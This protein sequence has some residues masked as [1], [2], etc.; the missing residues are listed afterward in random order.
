MKTIFKKKM[1]L[2][3]VNLLLFLFVDYYVYFYRAEVGT[4]FCLPWLIT[5]YGHVLNDVKHIIRLYDFFIACHP[6]MPI[7][8]AAAVSN[9]SHSIPEALCDYHKYNEHL[10]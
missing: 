2:S 3:D 8:L 6:L 1:Y 9:L 10:I 4:M 7:Y 5:W